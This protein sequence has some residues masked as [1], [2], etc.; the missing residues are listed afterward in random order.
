MKLN[1]DLLRKGAASYG[2]ALSDLQ[3]E[4]YSQYCDFLLET[5]KSFNLTAITNP[6]EV[7]SKH[8]CDSLASSLAFNFNEAGKMVDIGSGPGLPG[9][10]IKIAF[11]NLGL[12]AIESIGKK[13]RFLEE[14]TSKLGLTGVEVI[15]GRAEEIIKKRPEFISSFHVTVARAVGNIELLLGYA[16]PYLKKSG[17]VLLWKSRDEI[18]ELPKLA[19]RIM[20]MGFDVAETKPYKIPLW[21]L[22][23]FLVRLVRL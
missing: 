3:L 12:V 11:P 9:F 22:E 6:D 13:A 8:F 4:Q 16:K 20:Q 1:R 17:S 10:A 18:A 23:R 19:G 21:E 15:N 7:A 5:N 2:V 14:L